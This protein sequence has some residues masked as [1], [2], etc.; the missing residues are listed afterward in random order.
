M[1]DPLIEHARLI[2]MA[3]EIERNLERR[4]QLRAPRSQAAIKGWETRNA[5]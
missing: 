3:A 2:N 4:R 5:K 1:T